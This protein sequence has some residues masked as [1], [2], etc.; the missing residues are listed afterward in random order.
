MS[1]LQ[2]E[3]EMVEAAR[4]SGA[5]VTLGNTDALCPVTHHWAPGMYAREIL[6]PAGVLIVGKI[7]RHAHVNTVVRGHVWV[8]TEAGLHEI[9]GPHTFTSDPGTKRVVLA[10]QETV[11]ITYHPTDKET[12]AEV[13]ADIIAPSFDALTHNT[14]AAARG[15][16]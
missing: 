15:L 13:E 16:S 2:L 6:L 9:V 14:A 8:A 12:V 3:A 11:W 4:A 5:P 1:I 7:H 10:L